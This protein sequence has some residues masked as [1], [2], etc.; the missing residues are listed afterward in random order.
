MAVAVKG[1][2][3]FIQ[4]AGDSI[5]TGD[6]NLEGGRLHL[7]NRYAFDLSMTLRTDKCHRRELEP[8]PKSLVR[9]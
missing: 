7:M 2:G 8:G 4:N 3:I 9:T 1:S 6:S 5:L